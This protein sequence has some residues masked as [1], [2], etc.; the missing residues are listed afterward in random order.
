MQLAIKYVILAMALGYKSY[1]SF[2]LLPIKH[3][4]IGDAA[5]PKVWFL[6]LSEK[7][8]QSSSTPMRGIFEHHRHLYF[9][10][11]RLYYWCDRKFHN[12][13]DSI[14]VV[15]YVPCGKIIVNRVIQR[16]PIAHWQIV[17]NEAFNLLINFTRFEMDSS[18]NQCQFTNLR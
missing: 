5:V 15:D 14:N 9:S 2:Q 18:T 13:Q 16:I 17:M 6:Y 10:Y 3:T 1:D 11:S 12:N 4:A 8:Q 7:L